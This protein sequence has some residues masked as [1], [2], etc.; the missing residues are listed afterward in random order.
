M[1]NTLLLAEEVRS[2]IRGVLNQQNKWPLVAPV[3]AASKVGPLSTID[4]A[5]KPTNIF[6]LNPCEG[7]ARNKLNCAQ[8]EDSGDCTLSMGVVTVCL[9]LQ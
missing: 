7:S 3:A 6:G 1:C 4:V 9:H 5:A 2:Y 8:Y